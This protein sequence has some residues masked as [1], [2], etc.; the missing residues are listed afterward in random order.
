MDDAPTLPGGPPLRHLAT[1]LTASEPAVSAA[2]L[3]PPSRDFGDYELQGEVGRGGMG[4]VFR[5]RDKRLNR[6]VAVKMLLSSAVPSVAELQ[7]FHAEAAAAASLRHPGIVTIHQVGQV[8]G[9]PYFS[10]DFIDGRSLNQLLVDGPLPGRTAARYVT[11]IARAIHHAHE[12]GILHRDLKPANILIDVADRPL[13]TD[14]GLAKQF[15]ANAGQT[16]TGAVLGTPGFM[17][18]EQAAGRKDLGPCCDVYGLGALLYALITARPPFQAETPLDTLMQVMERDPAPPR[19]LNP[20]VDRDLETIC[21][22]CLQKEA[23]DRY[24][25]AADLAD[26]L[27]RYLAGDTIQARSLNVMD[28]IARTLGRSQQ[29]F[30]FRAY[31]AVLFWF[32]G[33]VAATHIVKHVLM[34]RHEA[35]SFIALTQLAQFCFMGLVFWRYRKQGMLPTTPAERQLWS[36]WVGYIATSI[37]ISALTKGMFGM[38]RLYD[39][40][41]YPYFAVVAGLSFF[42]LGSGYWGGFYAFGLAFFALSGSML[43]N[44]HW[45]CLEFGGLWTAALFL[46]GLRLRGLASRG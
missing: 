43:L 15:T 37:I 24:A 30:E 29:E 18:P 13:V 16:Q 28:V 3:L 23:R 35:A 34:A 39:Q 32:A 11:A 36:V 33:I 45:A 19:L 42:V 1:L 2:P 10:M 7:R 9:Q 40:V 25:S 21:L 44:L 38:S 22:K 5:A 31:S 14:F 26:D 20:K 12:K 8:E 17:A 27:D 4:V 6:T 46:I 41:D